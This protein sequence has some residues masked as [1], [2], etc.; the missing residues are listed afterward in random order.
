MNKK[1]L[2]SLLTFMMVAML[3]IGFASCGSDDDNE[4]SNGTDAITSK[5]LI[6]KWRI[7]EGPSSSFVGVIYTYNSDGTW[8]C[9]ESIYAVYTNWEISGGKLIMT[10]DDGRK[11]TYSAYISENRLY[12]TYGGKKIREGEVIDTSESTV[13][14]R[15]PDSN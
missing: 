5:S 8:E 3:S 9:S 11:E 13:L 1:Y 10:R 2:W 12:L 4:E 6:G 15:L 7:I 14:E